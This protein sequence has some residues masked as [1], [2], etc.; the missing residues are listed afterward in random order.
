MPTHTGRWV[1]LL[2]GVTACAGCV[3]DGTYSSLVLLLSLLQVAHQ[4]FA[5]DIL[6]A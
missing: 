1:G 2:A 5:Y 3:V 4:G 6:Q